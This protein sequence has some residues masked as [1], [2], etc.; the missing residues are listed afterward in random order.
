MDL[1]L[2][3]F[4]EN[5]LPEKKTLFLKNP[6][7]IQKLTLDEYVNTKLDIDI[8]WS[9]INGLHFKTKQSIKSNRVFFNKLPSKISLPEKY[10]LCKSLNPY[11]NHLENKSNFTDISE[12]NINIC[13]I[14]EQNKNIF[15]LIVNSELKFYPM[16]SPKWLIDGDPKLGYINLSTEWIDKYILDIIKLCLDSN[17]YYKKHKYLNNIDINIYYNCVNLDSYILKNILIEPKQNLDLKLKFYNFIKI[18]KP[19]LEQIKQSNII[20]AKSY[21]NLLELIWK[22]IDNIQDL[23]VIFNPI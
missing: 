11:E 5:I 2:S 14:F 17:E 13:K 15:P 4:I 20:D 9:L 8:F 7:E 18:Q 19:I 1:Q 23:Y 3:D 12:Y 10:L 16:V 22:G 6:I 21:N